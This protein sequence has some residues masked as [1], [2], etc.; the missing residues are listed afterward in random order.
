MIVLRI[1]LSLFL[2]LTPFAANAG[3]IVNALNY[4][5]AESDTQFKGYVAKAGGIGKFL[6]LREV[7]SVK[8]RPR[9]AAIATRSTRSACTTSPRRS[10]S[11]N[12]ISRPVSIVAG[13][14]PG[15]IQSGTEERRRGG[16]AEHRLG[17]HAI[18]DGAVPH[19]LRPE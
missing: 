2:T 4:V 19:V 13:D 3:E 14:R 1:T 9:F 17:W 15:S 5:R 6:N 11:S 7:Y 18:R 10:R 8:I 16:D 12:R